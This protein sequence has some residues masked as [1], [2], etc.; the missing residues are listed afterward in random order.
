MNGEERELP[1]GWILTTLD[2]IG[3]WSS[4]GTPSRT[5]DDFFGGLI[6]WVKT[7]ELN[8]GLVS[9]AEETISQAGLENSSAKIF[10]KGSLV[11]AMYG[12]TIGRLGILATEAAT[13]QACAVLKAEG[14]T[15]NLIPYVFRYLLGE[16]Q[17]FKA[18]GQGGA[19]PNI[20]Q[21]VIKSYPFVLAPLPEQR[22]IVDALDSY[23]TRLDAATAG[24]RR[25]EA[26]LKRYRASVLKAAVEGRLVPTE[27]ELA[28]AEGRE[29]EPASVL[30]ERI[31]VERR[32]RWEEAE[33]EKM[34]AA[35]KEPKSDQWKAKYK[36]PVGP[37]V[38]GLPELPEGW[39]WA[40]LDSLLV[41]IEA[42]KN[43]KCKELPPEE[44]E[45]GV[46][47][48]SAVTWGTF[49]EEESKTS[50]RP[51]FEIERLLIGEGDFL[52]SR[53]NT[54]QLVGAVVIAGPVRRR[55]MLSDKILRLRLL[56]DID[57]WILHVLRSFIGRSQIEAMS[58][59][60]QD[61]MRN[62]SQNNIRKITIP[63]PPKRE[64]ERSLELLNIKQSAGDHTDRAV[65]QTT[66][67][68][69]RLRQSILK[70]AFEGKLVDQNPDDE[71]AADLLARI[72][73]ERA[74][75]GKTK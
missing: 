12:A 22:R 72:R 43:F 67:R 33:L 37:D 14:L 62:I 30:L 15:K 68:I 29:Y 2:E 42:G 49:N 36:E 57:Q 5:R 65:Q 16:R 41:L 61:S 53:A 10:P 11:I 26:N 71:S 6:P 13:N 24:L 40:S 7:G 38:E 46:V 66:L 64:I 60:N 4:G 25:V 73:A 39:C 32:R 18:L 19:Q 70:W 20:S 8:D 45:T 28:R 59:G 56:G 51:E 58:S 1:E 69:D 34:R 23:L 9:Q 55:L 17:N 44:G 50:L 21:G 31:L 63:I 75:K 35:G 74:Q 3:S 27:A 54:L 52:F 48:V 47:K